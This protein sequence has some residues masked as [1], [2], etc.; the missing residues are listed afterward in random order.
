MSNHTKGR[1]Y[2]PSHH[3]E[4]NPERISNAPMELND[5]IVLGLFKYQRGHP[6]STANKRRYGYLKDH[7]NRKGPCNF[8]GVVNYYLDDSISSPLTVIVRIRILDFMIQF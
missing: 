7:L 4:S 8:I 3:S 6:T 5:N 1:L 2:K